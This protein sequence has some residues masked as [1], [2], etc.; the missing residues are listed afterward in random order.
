MPDRFGA[1]PG[2]EETAIAVT[3]SGRRPLRRPGRVAA[4]CV[5][6]AARRS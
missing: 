1:G 2:E 6:P 5:R 4:G 3:I